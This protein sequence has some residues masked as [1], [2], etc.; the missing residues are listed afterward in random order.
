METQENPNENETT[1]DESPEEFAEQVENDPST[2]KS[3]DADDP[4]EQVRGG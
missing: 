3:G 1:G 2:A 4:L